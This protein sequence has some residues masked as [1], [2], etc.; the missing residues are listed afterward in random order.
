MWKREIWQTIFFSNT[1]AFGGC[2]VL[3]SI[4]AGYVL[5]ALNWNNPIAKGHLASLK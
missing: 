2:N 1:V 4:M 5:K 3:K